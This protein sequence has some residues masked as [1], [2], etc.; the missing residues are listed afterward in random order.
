MTQKAL[1]VHTPSGAAGPT[2]DALNEH[3]RA[4]WRVLQATPMGGGGD[5]FASLVVIE[6]AAETEA[7]ALLEQIEEE[8]EGDGAPDV[9]Q[10]PVLR[11]LQDDEPERGA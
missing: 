7:E 11:R 1:V 4:G 2:L 5:G 9:P 6:R 10:D 8:M 3:L